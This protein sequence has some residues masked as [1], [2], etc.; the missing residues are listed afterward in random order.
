M[1]NPI[2]TVVGFKG[3]G[4]GRLALRCCMF[5]RFVAARLGV[6]TFEMLV[7][8][9]YR[10]VM[11]ALPTHHSGEGG[12]ERVPL[13]QPHPPPLRGRQRRGDEGRHEANKVSEPS[14]SLAVVLH[15]L[16][17]VLMFISYSL[18]LILS[19]RA[20]TDTLCWCASLHT[21]V[22]ADSF[23]FCVHSIPLWCRISVPVGTRFRSSSVTRS[24]LIVKNRCL[25]DLCRYLGC[26]SYLTTAGH[27][28]PRA[29]CTSDM[30]GF[31]V[32]LRPCSIDLIS[33][34]ELVQGGLQEGQD[35][36]VRLDRQHQNPFQGMRM[37]V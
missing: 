19:A 26:W 31:L 21:A 23:A 1:P 9:T 15:L 5:F 13:R 3:D 4:I 14:T 8:C 34:L 28:P 20:S 29:W 17:L 36:R 33:Q 24:S 10:L 25:P 7:R 37:H 6:R 12:R 18:V 35:W 2:A 30:F 11:L 22:G 32:R 27:G 16:F